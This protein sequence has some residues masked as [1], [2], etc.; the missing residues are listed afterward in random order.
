MGKMLK[1]NATLESQGW[2]DGH[3]VNALV[4]VR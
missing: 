2:Q 3:I 1:A 4:F